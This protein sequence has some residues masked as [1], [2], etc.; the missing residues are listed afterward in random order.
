MPPNFAELPSRGGTC[1]VLPAPMSLP[2]PVPA[3]NAQVA[4]MTWIDLFRGA[5]VV[6][7]IETHVLNTFLLAGSRASAWFE[8]LNYFNGLVAP[9]FLFIAGYLQGL[10]M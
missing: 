2:V 4:R 6:M 5:A 8:W 9:S 10:G 3:P 7:M 1:G